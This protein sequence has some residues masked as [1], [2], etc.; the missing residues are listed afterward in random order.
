MIGKPVEVPTAAVTSPIQ[1]RTVIRKPSAR[2]VLRTT[3]SIIALGTFL[4]ALEISSL[5]WSTPSKPVRISNGLHQSLVGVAAPVSTEVM[6][7][8]PIHHCTPSLSQ[9]L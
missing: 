5:R 9:P 8:S 6:E 1:K 4:G 3:A 7:R 2:T